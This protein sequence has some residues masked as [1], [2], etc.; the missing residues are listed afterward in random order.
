MTATKTEVK[1]TFERR[2]MQ[3]RFQRIGY[4]TVDIAEIKDAGHG[5]RK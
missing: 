5:N 2:E 1:I 3:P 4:N